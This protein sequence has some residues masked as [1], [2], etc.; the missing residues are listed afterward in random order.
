[1]YS[2]RSLEEFWLEF[3]FW[4]LGQKNQQIRVPKF[5]K[6]WLLGLFWQYFLKN[7]NYR[8]GRRSENLGWRIGIRC[9]GAAAAVVS[10]IC[11]NG[12]RGG[13]QPVR[14][15]FLF[16]S[17]WIRPQGSQGCQKISIFFS[18]IKLLSFCAN[19]APK[20]HKLWKTIKIE[21]KC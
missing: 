4:Q 11:Q 6:S 9:A 10:L 16:K 2:W 8:D 18:Q 13:T 12:G 5:K 7:R 19:I 1:M 20:W 3:L 17:I 15:L 21:K 14:T